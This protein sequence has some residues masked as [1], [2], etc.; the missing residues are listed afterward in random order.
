M[1]KSPEEKEIENFIK[2]RPK[3]DYKL[4]NTFVIET[5]HSKESGR[6][7]YAISKP[8]K[9]FSEAYKTSFLIEKWLNH[10]NGHFEG[11]KNL[12]YAISHCQICPDPF[13][14]FTVCEEMAN[15][16]NLPDSRTRNY[17]NFYFKAQTIFNAE[18]LEAPEQI[19]ADTAERVMNPDLTTKIIT[20]EKMVSNIINVPD[21]CMSF[22]LKKGKNVDIH[23]RIKVR[24]QIRSWYGFK[25][26]TEWVEGLKAHVL[27]HEIMHSQG[28]NIYY[29][30]TRN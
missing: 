9:A 16:F 10:N 3:D 5:K 29:D 25:T 27:Q 11:D 24:Y 1:D 22:P 4:D 26:I 23:F 17:T 15:P 8:V 12:A 30:K 20:K 2:D 28:R 21:A 14:M 13:A 18:I 7:I 19:M 6:G